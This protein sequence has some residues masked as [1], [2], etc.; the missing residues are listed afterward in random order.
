[1]KA[2]QERS[3]LEGVRADQLK[4][5]GEHM[6][7]KRVQQRR[8]IKSRPTGI[9]M[10]CHEGPMSQP[11]RPMLSAGRI[12]QVTMSPIGPGADTVRGHGAE[13]GSIAHTKE[14]LL[15]CVW[16]ALNTST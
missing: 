13:D 9:S 8:H 3:H 15:R 16:S 4:D 7:Q 12:A 11:S 6:G 2:S 10:R 14:M 5:L 1:M